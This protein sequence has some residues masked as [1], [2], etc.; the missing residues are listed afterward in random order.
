ME[1]KGKGISFFLG[2]TNDIYI[3]RQK[4]K[5]KKKIAKMKKIRIFLIFLL[6]IK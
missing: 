1:K 6:P 4:R 3:K 5:K 2:K